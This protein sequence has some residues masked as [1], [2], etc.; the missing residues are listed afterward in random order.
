MT[1]NA[2]INSL[3]DVGQHH[4]HHR[5]PRGMGPGYWDWGPQVYYVQPTYA[6]CAWYEDPT[7][8]GG[9]R[10]P[11]MWLV[12]AGLGLTALGVVVSLARR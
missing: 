1:N 6:Q 8:G 7:A 11:A 10:A 2:L 3:G 12:F 4:H 9:C 5:W